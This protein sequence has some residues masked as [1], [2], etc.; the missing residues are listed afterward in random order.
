MIDFKRIGGEINSSPLNENFRKLQDSISMASTNIIFPEE[1]G[2]VATVADMNAIPNPVTAQWCYVISNG[3]AY[4]YSG[5]TWIKI[6][7]FGETFKQSFLNNG[8]V[9]LENPITIKTGSST[10]LNIPSMLVYFKDKPGDDVYLRGMYKVTGFEYNIAMDEV[11]TGGGVYSLFITDELSVSVIENLPT[12]DY[13]D[14]IFLGII[15]VTNDI[16]IVKDCVYTMPD[17]AY[18]SDRG[19]FIFQGGQTQGCSLIGS[20]S[21][22]LSVGRQS[23]FYYDEG[24]NYPTGLINNYPNDNNTSSNFNLKAFPATNTSEMYYLFQD[25]ISSQEDLIPVSTIDVTHYWDGNSLETVPAGKF[26][27]QRH[28]ISPTGQNFVYYGDTLYDSMTDALAN[29]NNVSALGAQFLY[30]EATRIVVKQG[31]TDTSDTDQIRFIT[32]SKLTQVGTIAPEF[33]DS[34]FI[35]YNDNR[36]L[37]YNLSNITDGATRTIQLLDKSYTLA[38]NADVTAIYEVLD[39]KLG[40]NAKINGL[41]FIETEGIPEIT[42]TTTNIGEGNNKYYTEARVSANTD[43]AA[44]TA[45][46]NTVSGNPHGSTTNDITV[47]NDKNY[48]SSAQL[49]KL[50]NLPTA[51]N[52]NQIEIYEDNSLINNATKKLNFG[53]GL[54]A[55][56]DGFNPE[57][58][59][60]NIDG[61]TLL[62]SAD[63]ADGTMVHEESTIKKVKA[64]TI[65]EEALDIYGSDTAGANKYFGTDVDS[66]VDWHA[67]PTYVSTVAEVG[68]IISVDDILYVPVD[69]SVTEDKLEVSVQNKLNAHDTITVYDSGVLVSDIVTRINFGSN[70]DVVVNDDLATVNGT[71]EGGVG[72]VTAFADLDDVNITYDPMNDGKI[73]TID[74]TTSKIVMSDLPSVGDIMLKDD[75]ASITAGKVLAAELADNATNALALQNKVVND[76]ITSSSNLWTAQK[77]SQ[78]ISAKMDGYYGVGAPNDEMGKDGDI[79][80]ELMEV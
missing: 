27:T 33:E 74:S 40:S 12:Q 3:G 59:N 49:T 25:D 79:Y 61:A 18:T 13:D 1:N 71:G 24:V 76:T 7:D 17:I 75:Y 56:I 20:L 37:K 80:I 64:S 67:L 70:L 66:I 73:L 60:V 42:L 9:L 65:A 45:H 29:M 36:N 16:K 32:T 22:D 53:N 2:I 31:A 43:V 14:K 10:I 28:I 58:T 8:V 55:E 77:T 52:I 69:G 68:G 54:I 48:I 4:R 57:K 30:A 23:G 34:S 78:M 11:I 5:S 21:S 50:N 6:G 26:T 15:I 51:T 46:R 62:T 35:I 41:P 44:N 63:Y 39:N 19:Y 47:S 38:D 72:G